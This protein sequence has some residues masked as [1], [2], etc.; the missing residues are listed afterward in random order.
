[1]SRVDFVCLM[2]VGFLSDPYFTRGRN[3]G[4]NLSPVVSSEPQIFHCFQTDRGRFRTS[5]VELAFRGTIE[6]WLAVS[7]IRNNVPHFSDSWSRTEY[8]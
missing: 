4:L 5:L 2:N 8:L 7:L 6:S 1:M 3:S